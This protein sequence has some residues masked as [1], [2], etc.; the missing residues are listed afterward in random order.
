MSHVWGE[1]GW[2]C[3][4]GCDKK[5]GWEAEEGEELRHGL[6]AVLSYWPTCRCEIDMNMR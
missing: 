3:G 1:C 5:Q 4:A 6:F 2:R